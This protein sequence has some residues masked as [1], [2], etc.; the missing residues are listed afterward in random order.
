MKKGVGNVTVGVVLVLLIALFIFSFSQV[1]ENPF[2]SD[3]DEVNSNSITGFSFHDKPPSAKVF[4]RDFIAERKKKLL[5][6]EIPDPVYLACVKQFCADSDAKALNEDGDPNIK[7]YIYGKNEKGNCIKLEDSC[8][9]DKIVK[10]MSCKKYFDKK[11]TINFEREKSLQAQYDAI[12]KIVDDLELQIAGLEKKLYGPGSA[13]LSAEEKKELQQDLAELQQQYEGPWQALMNLEAELT[14]LKTKAGYPVKKFPPSINIACQYGCKDGACQPKP[15]APSCKDN[16]CNQNEDCMYSKSI[17]PDCGGVCPKC[18]TCYDN[19]QNQG[20]TGVD[21]G[22]PCNACASCSDGKWNQDEDLVDCG[23]VCPA[24]SQDKIDQC[25]NKLK[26]NDETSIDC[27]GKTCPACKQDLPNQYTPSCFNNILDQNE[28]Q[29]DCGGDCP[30]CKSIDPTCSDKKKNGYETGIDCGGPQCPVCEAPGTGCKDTDQ[31]SESNNWASNM[32]GTVTEKNNPTTYEDECIDNKN[33]KEYVCSN[34]KKKEQF[35]PCKDKCFSDPKGPD[36][37]TEDVICNDPDANAGSLK[38][39]YVFGEYEFKFE[40]AIP[41]KVTVASTNGKQIAS[42]PDTCS[43]NTLIEKYCNGDT[44]KE[45]WEY[46]FDCT[47]EVAGEQPFDACSTCGGAGFCCKNKLE[48]KES[49]SGKNIEQAAMTLIPPLCDCSGADSSVDTCGVSYCE[50]LEGGEAVE[51]TSATDT[52][53]KMQL[54]SVTSLGSF[55]DAVKEYYCDGLSIKSQWI[56]CPEGEACIK[57]ACKPYKVCVDSDT[58]K[59]PV[60]SGT[61]PG[62]ASGF[63]LELGKPVYEGTIKDTCLNNEILLEAICG[64]IKSTQTPYHN[65]GTKWYDPYGNSIILKTLAQP[66]YYATYE[67][68]ICKIC[69]KNKDGVFVCMGKCVESEKGAYCDITKSPYS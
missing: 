17:I 32:P 60:T 30:P 8:E 6:K 36:Y 22:G 50:Q 53:C 47:F 38:V 31:S 35:Y 40:R 15:E 63:V 48:C 67:P 10:E 62:Q 49:D 54:N 69:G 11:Y 1:G 58:E 45:I 41:S 2:P 55:G 68:H 44:G 33:L 29:V 37:C 26:D 23:G 51:T 46:D 9:T 18:A 34:N 52:Y 25:Y 65:V 24:C 14:F 20:E 19:K 59:Y 66:Q 4:K 56:V 28:E 21:C 39:D 3:Y 42:S 43:G 12:K 13:T 5:K 61:V 7:G 64:G 57:G 27:G 16:K